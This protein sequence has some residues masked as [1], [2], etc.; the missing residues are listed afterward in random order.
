MNYRLPALV[1]L[2]VLCAALATGVA[3]RRP[4]PA[5][6]P[7]VLSVAFA[8]PVEHVRHEKLREGQTLATLLR[9]LR[10]EQEQATAILSQLGDSTASG[11]IRAGRELDLRLDAERGGVR[12]M[13]LQLDADRVLRV[14][15]RRGPV[16]ARVDSVQVHT[17]TAVFSGSVRY[18]LYEALLNGHGDVPRGERERLGDQIADHIFA[19]RIDFTRDL[20]RGDRYQILYERTV[21]P[22]GT[23]RRSRL[24][25]VR[26]LLSGHLH[27]A[28]LY[29]H[30][31]VD[32]W[33]DAKGQS[34]KRG[35]L[36]APLEFRA[37]SS[38]FSRARWHPILHIMRAHAGI[39]YAAAP[40]TPVHAVADGVVKRAG[41]SGGYGNLIELG[42]ARG[43]STRYGHLRAIA[44]G[45]RAGARVKQGQVVGYVGMTGLAT[46]PH[47]HYEFRL[48]EQA[49]NPASVKEIAGEPVESGPESR[50]RQ[51]VQARIAALERADGARLA[52]A[53]QGRSAGNR[54]G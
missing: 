14:D 5:A 41:W 21:R 26:F 32:G 47:L 53:A 24:L 16:R 25:A 33:Y 40:G 54:G 23:A 51:L 36:R 44:P 3:G 37:I 43:Y 52:D 13:T 31:G 50:F 39:D 17:D 6:P 7:R 29:R 11:T 15:G 22:D 48:Q 38:G 2:G 9:R 45:V 28:F 42:H 10:L 35:F 18:S 12:R 8:N 20:Q 46:G 19:T 4:Q 34:L 27:E 30:D 49:V 1:L